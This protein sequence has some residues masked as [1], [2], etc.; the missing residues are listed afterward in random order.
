MVFLKVNNTILAI[1]NIVEEMNMI[2][3]MGALRR[4]LIPRQ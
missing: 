2:R 3:K 1:D 4:G